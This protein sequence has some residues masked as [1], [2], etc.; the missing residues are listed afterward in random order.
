MRVR[1]L[2][3]GS[4][5]LLLTALDPQLGARMPQAQTVARV[6]DAVERR[7]VAGLRTLLEKGADP[8]APQPDGATALHWAV[9][10][11]DGEA[12]DLLIR[13]GAKVD[14]VNDLGVFPLSLACAHG[15][16]AMAARLIRAGASPRDALPSGE[17][18]LMTCART[19]V[20]E[21]VAPL[22]SGG[23]DVNA[24]ETDRGQTALMW[25]AA[26]KHPTAVKALIAN[27]ADVNAASAGGF[28]PLMFAAREGDPV[29]AELL[30]SAGA[31]IDA[32]TPSGESALL[33]AAAS[34]AGLTARDYRVVAE[35][36]GHEAVAT[37]LVRRGANVDRA[38]ALGMT[39]LHHAV[40][41]G[42]R[43]LLK[44]LI[45]HG[46]NVNARLLQGLP[47]RRGDYVSRGG[48]GGATPLW[49]A[50]MHGDVETMRTLVAAG[51]DWRLPSRNGTTPLMVAAG[52]G[53]TDSRIPPESR[54]LA[55]VEY[56]V[57]L[58][59]D[60][61]QANTGGQTAVHGAAS[62]SG[63]SIL[64]FLASKGAILDAKD[65]GGRTAIDVTRN[66]QRPRPE[67]EALIRKLL[68]HP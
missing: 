48:F 16:R 64:G 24:R 45:D 10:W 22:V 36:S 40:E 41:T 4:A 1:R 3:T 37:L 55:A 32:V 66:I 50:A 60:V 67:T 2:A 39:A 59:G 5:A 25:A 18:A 56:L 13:A 28:T 47:F 14:A 7:D 12:A 23:A 35:P 52:V 54:L 63:H 9:H 19:G 33:V 65:K 20:D 57:S 17:S 38:D 30:L 8:N 15:N 11:D 68:Q 34:V 61:N 6:A 58:G 31:H 46:A 43:D 44:A 29:S 26:G 42:K 49:L 27:G 21:V 53:Q 51:A 62:I